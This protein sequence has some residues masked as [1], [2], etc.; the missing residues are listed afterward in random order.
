MS[1]HSFKKTPIVTLGRLLW[2]EGRWDGRWEEEG[3][4]PTTLYLSLPLSLSLYFLSLCLSQTLQSAIAIA[5]ASALSALRERNRC[6]LAHINVVLHVLSHTNISFL[7]IHF[8][9]S[10]KKLKLELGGSVF[11]AIASLLC[12]PFS[13]LYGDRGTVREWNKCLH[14]STPSLCSLLKGLQEAGIRIWRFCI[15]RLCY[16]CHLKLTLPQSQIL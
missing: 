6:L 14:T 7:C 12:L 4:H 11:N 3:S 16:F 15:H 13:L 10:S 2:G 5:I 1:S 9:K 8:Q